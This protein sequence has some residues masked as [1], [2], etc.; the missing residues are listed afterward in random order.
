VG[1]MVNDVTV[2]QVSSEYV[3]LPPSVSCSIPIPNLS[4][5]DDICYQ[6]TVSLNKTSTLDKFSN[7][8]KDSDIKT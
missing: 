4:P 3:R 2:R 5:I 6:L 1:F 8:C 7:I